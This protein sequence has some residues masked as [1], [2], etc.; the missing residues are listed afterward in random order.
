MI[1]AHHGLKAGTGTTR[2]A[3]CRGAQNHLLIMLCAATKLVKSSSWL[4]F[5]H[6]RYTSVNYLTSAQ[7]S[8]LAGVA[9]LTKTSFLGLKN[10]RVTRIRYCGRI[11]TVSSGFI[12]CKAPV[13]GALLRPRTYRVQV[14]HVHHDPQ[15]K[16]GGAVVNPSGIQ[17]ALQSE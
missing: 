17:R 4:L 12:I 9:V 2:L 15:Q 1:E 3:H 8:V 7:R 11:V 13:G 6:A 16:D 5:V 14:D 10:V